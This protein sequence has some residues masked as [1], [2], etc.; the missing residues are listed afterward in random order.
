MKRQSGV[1]FRKL[2][3]VLGVMLFGILSQAAV[4]RADGEGTTGA[5]FL[6]IGTSSRAEAMG[7]AFI[8]VVDDV[9]AIYWNPAGLTQ[10]RRS[11]IGFTHLE[12]FEGIR[13]EYL[14]YA[15]KYDYVGAVG[16]SLGYLYLGDIPKA[17]ETSSGDYDPASSG[18]F[19]ASDLALNFAWAGNLFWRENKIGLGLKVI[20]EAIEDSQTFSVGV[21]IGDQILL[22]RTRWYRAAAKDNWAVRLVP[23]VVGISFRN[24]GTPVKYSYQNDPL[25]MIGQLGLAYKFLDDDLATAL[26]LE[27]RMVEGLMVF[28]LGAEYWIH[29]GIRSGPKSTLDVALRGGYRTGYDA[30]SAPGFSLGL[31]VQYSSLGL[32]YV[33]MPFGDLGMTHRIS[34]KFSWGDELKEKTRVKR[35]RLVKRALSPSEKALRDTAQKMVKTKKSMEG[36]VVVRKK[37]RATTLTEVEAK[38]P[39]ERAVAQ[40]AKTLGADIQVKAAQPEEVKPAISG[41]H[42]DTTALAARIAQRAKGV[43]TTS[44]TTSRYSRRTKEDVIRAAKQE[45]TQKSQAFEDVES[46]AQQEARQKQTALVTRT[47]VYFAKNSAKLNDRYLYALDQIAFSHDK[48]PQRTILVHGY[49]STDEKNVNALSRERAKAVKDYLVQIKSISGSKISVK[50]FGDTQPAASNNTEKGRARN[51]RV[52]VQIIQAGN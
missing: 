31:G 39:E 18:T 28:H 4:S 21:D 41:G 24:L 12:W 44:R 9:D 1:T 27:Y 42:V 26:D 43:R 6:K 40:E 16:V 5:P 45:A 22:S 19:G 2:G 23:S 50:G 47:T 20:Q 3:V 48:Y 38:R 13:Y 15:D 34:L 33:F 11:T 30:T 25:P 8:G 35:R 10:L 29:T 36:R 32:D 37:G 51:R 7:G 49:C 17:L 14:S 46:A 52:R